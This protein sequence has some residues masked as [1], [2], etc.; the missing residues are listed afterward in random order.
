MILAEIVGA[1]NAAGDL[2]TLYF[3]A[4]SYQTGPSEMPANINFEAR[5]TDSGSIGVS[6]YGDGRTTGYGKLEVGSIKVGNIDGELDY[7]AD[8]GFDG[9]PITL[10][11]YQPGQTYASMPVIFTGT[12]DALPEFSTKEITF[13]LKDQQQRLE[14]P[15]CPNLYG[16]SNVLPNGIDGV[17]GD[18]KGKRKARLWGR[19]LNISP[20]CVNTS[21]QIFRVNDGPVQEITAA[22]DKGAPYTYD[23]DYAD[24]AAL[25]AA[26][27]PAGYYATCVAEGLFRIN[28]SIAGAVTCDVVQGANAN[29]RTAAQIIR[30]IALGA[31]LLPSEINASDVAIMDGT[32]PAEVGIYLTG[33]ITA[34]EAIS[35]LATSVGGYAIFDNVAMLRVGILTAPAGEPDLELTDTEMLSFER[36]AQRDGDIPVSEVRLNHTRNWTVQDNDLA[37]SV[38]VARRNFLKEQWRTAPASDPLVKLRYLLAPTYEIASLIYDPDNTVDGPAAKEAARQLSL[39]RV[40]RDLFEIKVDLDIF[41]EESTPRL[42]SLVRVTTAR[43]QAA[44]GRLFWLVGVR[45]ELKRK[46]A[47]LTVWG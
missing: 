2:E 41:A 10:R 25:Q 27:I 47:T 24:N 19:C 34:R 15:A 39:Y 31:G 35:Q 6:V 32:Q 42:M 20:D 28:A 38:S 33:E 3:S 17:D 14:V 18:L 11:L 45:L 40:R 26:T 46:Q 44:G 37:G 43:Y 16:G 23:A 1:K 9:R 5:L 22:Y 36:L 13:R 21:L 12:V 7:L 8:Y 30:S 29:N 4:V